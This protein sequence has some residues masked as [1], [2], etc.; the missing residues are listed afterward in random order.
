MHQG[1]ESIRKGKLQMAKEIKRG[2]ERELG[3]QGEPKN[4]KGGQKESQS[5]RHQQS[6]IYG[7]QNGDLGAY[8]D[9][10]INESP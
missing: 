10:I 9:Q 7:H 2:S 1:I 4:V 8:V 5:K 6:T 3:T